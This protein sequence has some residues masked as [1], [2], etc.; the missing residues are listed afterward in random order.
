MSLIRHCALPALAAIALAWSPS[1]ASATLKGV[2]SGS[3][4]MSTA[5]KSVSI[6]AVDTTQSF[7]V[8]YGD[9]GG[10]SYK[11]TALATCEL[12]AGNTLTVTTSA[13]DATLTVS[14]YV[15][16]FTNGV[17]VQ[18]GLA[19]MSNSGSTPQT[20]DVGI[21][22]VNLAQSFVLI[23][24][25]VN[26]TTDNKD[27]DWTVRA[28]LTSTTNLRL[29][30][31]AIN[32]L[33]EPVA[34][35]VV[36][37]SS[38]SVQS[39]ST[40]INAGS[41]STTAGITAVDTTKSFVV[42]SRSGGSGVGGDE[43][44]Y[45]V[46]GVLTNTTTLTFS[47]MSSGGGSRQAYVEWFVVSLTDGSSV[48]RNLCGPSGTGGASATMPATPAGCLT[49][50]PAITTGSSVP[51]I[52]ARGDASSGSPTQD[53]DDTSWRPALSDSAIA[54]TRSSGASLS[55]NSTVAWQVVQ[56]SGSTSVTLIDKREVFQ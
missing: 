5:S 20:L 18:R 55:S 52:S 48:Q 51:F 16:E 13:A 38:A 17:T 41:V 7:V 22:A 46:T 9:S 27:E 14:W 44:L 30:R 24:Q 33:S 50:S 1:A 2:Q 31:E 8:C 25:R 28:K 37:I 54:L 3:V 53:L 26:D 12:N 10:L 45:Q 23:T 29:T 40:T 56:F 15:V 35:Q 21:T 11:P 4:T 43:S 47:R 19:T 36:Q 6:T 49:L 39:G 42:F 32:G 34:W